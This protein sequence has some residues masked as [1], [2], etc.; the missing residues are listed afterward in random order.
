MP[1]A[2]SIPAA[3]AWRTP[4]A[5]RRR[6]DVRNDLEAP[7]AE[8]HPEIGRIVASLKR[9]GRVHAA[10]SGSGSAVFGLFVDAARPRRRP[11]ALTA[12]TRR[13]LVTRTLESR[14]RIRRSCSPARRA[15]RHRAPGRPC[16]RS[17]DR[18]AGLAAETSP[19]YT[20]TVCATWLRPLLRSRSLPSSVSGHDG[21]ALQPRTVGWE[22][23]AA[24]A[25]RRCEM[26]R[27]QAVRRGTLDPVFEGSNPSAPANL[28]RG[29]SRD[30]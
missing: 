23:R 1:T 18:Q 3:S 29:L 24:D 7:V 30:G 5:F 17:V 28:R 13:A 20:L 14:A 12:A 9:P 15:V 21:S 25:D 6:D 22:L 16:A 8:R 27:G 10:M 26:G 4:V 2:T 19:S 11:A